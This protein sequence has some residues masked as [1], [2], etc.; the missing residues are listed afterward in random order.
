MKMATILTEVCE[1]YCVSKAEILG[2]SHY[3]YVCLPRQVLMYRSSKAGKTYGQIGNFLGR[4]KDSV[5]HGV[6]RI[7]ERLVAGTLEIQ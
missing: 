4:H 3:K 7:T 6:K 5:R 2:R 1:T